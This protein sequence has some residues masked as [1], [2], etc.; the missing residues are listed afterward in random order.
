[1]R[2]VLAILL[3]FSLAALGAPPSTSGRQVAPIP[4][5]KYITRMVPASGK[6]GERELT[7]MAI[8]RRPDLEKLRGAITTATA[9]KRAAHD[10]VNPELRFSYAQG[11]DDR[12][13]DPYTE[14]ETA[15]TN[16]SES[17]DKSTSPSSALPPTATSSGSTDNNRFREIERLVTPGLTKDIVEERIY[18]TNTSSTSS[19]SSK[20]SSQYETESR[21]LI[22]TTRKV[23]D[24]AN[25][26]G[27]D[28]TWGVLLRFTLPNPWERKARIQR[29]AA[30]ISL[31][32]AEY[33][34]AEDVVVRKVRGA[35]QELAILHGKLAAQTRRKAGFESYRDWIE[36]QNVPQ[37]G[38]DLA[39]ARAKVYGTLSDIRSLE[40][41]ITAMRDDLAA[42]CGLADA[43]RIE[44]SI[45]TR[46]VRNPAALDVEYL[47]SIAMLYRSDVL[48]DQARLAIAR[49][50]LS[51]VKA[52]RI[53]VTTFVDFGYSQTE[54]L[55]SSGQ[56]DESFARIGVSFPLW[57]WVGFNKQ[58][59]VHEAASQSLERQLTMQQTVV[60]NE[61]KQA[62]K[63]L[64]AAEAQLG[65]HDKD[66]AD[67]HADLT[68]SMADAQIVTLNVDDLAKG[69]RIE[70]DFKDL[71]QQMELSRFSSLSAYQEALMALEKTLGIRL[72]RALS[73][74]GRP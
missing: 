73:Q 50:Q 24:H 1:M 46:L 36:K 17:F 63:R 15:L 31:A 74:A 41:N 57:D 27:E 64:A 10:L 14:R 43:S 13:R 60:S 61:V 55:R 51:A 29:A 72:E 38:L 39:S 58:H 48:G 66:L 3:L 25:T 69:A 11:E 42:F 49:A 47:T 59:T 68:K 5:A 18:E 8:A 9:Q 6:L 40:S 35:F 54:S 20:P 71:V 19:T 45:K 70:Q 37:L 28:N 30:E 44:T 22:G 7:L 32:E 52:Q 16:S 53:P 4:S 62:V 56:K 12:I 34:A 33:Y 23:V 26:T 65:V 2:R 67:I 21:K